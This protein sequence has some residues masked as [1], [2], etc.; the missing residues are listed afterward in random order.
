MQIE[1][2]YRTVAL[3]KNL[4]WQNFGF[5]FAKY[6]ILGVYGNTEPE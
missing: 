1:P 4:E 6:I 5:I 2:E 3:N